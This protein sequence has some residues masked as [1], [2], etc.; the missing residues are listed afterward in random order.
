MKI[1]AYA[2]RMDIMRS[3]VLKRPYCDIVFQLTEMTKCLL[4][5]L[6]RR[7]DCRT[8]EIL[9]NLDEWEVGSSER[10]NIICSFLLLYINIYG[11]L[12]F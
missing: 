2:R 12:A 10:F 5:E 7:L 1:Q 6:C 4:E 11:S 3:K 8:P 9:I